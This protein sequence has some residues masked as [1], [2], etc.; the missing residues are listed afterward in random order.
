MYQ[1]IL[2]PLD[3][4]ISSEAVLPHA[5]RLARELNA[6]IVLL[7][8]RV[9]PAPQFDTHV[10][11]FAPELKEIRQARADDKFYIKA[12]CNRLED[13]DLRATYLLRDGPVVETII[14]VA[15]VMQADLIAMSTHGKS[16]AKLLLLGSV[17]Y[18]VVRNSPIPALVIRAKP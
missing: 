16:G 13:D 2:V 8:V 7:H 9:T 17:T 4:S 12:V 6:E 10:S 11:P 5:E 18:Q 3:G 1:R 15:E 14:E